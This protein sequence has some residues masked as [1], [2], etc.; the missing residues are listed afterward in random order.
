MPI[1]ARSFIAPLATNNKRTHNA[2]TVSLFLGCRQC[3]K[4]DTANPKQKN[5]IRKQ[6]YKSQNRNKHPKAE[7]R[8][9]KYK[10]EL[11]N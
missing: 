4:K 9:K 7:A 5:T 6:K 1:L 11:Q 8:T 2:K 10:T 3:K